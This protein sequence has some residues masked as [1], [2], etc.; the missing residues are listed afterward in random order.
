[1]EN[2]QIYPGSLHNHTEYSNLRLRDCIIRPE[3]LIDYA[4]EL[5]QEV[6]AITDHECVS[7][8]VRVEKYYN[9]IKENNPNFKLIRG[10]EIYLV[11]NGLNAD[12]YNRETDRYYH[13][14]LLAKDLIGMKQIFEISTRAWKR[15]YMARGMRR[16]PTYYQ[17]LIDVIGKNPGHIIGSTACLG[18]AIPVQILRAKENKKLLPLIENWLQQ[19]DSIFGHGNFFLELQP[20]HNKDQ[21]YVNK[22]LLQYSTTLNIPYIITTDSHYLKKEDRII[23]KAYLNAQN[24]D[25]EVDSFYATTYLMDTNELEGYFEYFSKEQ[26][27]EA[28]N[29]IKKI[30]DMCEDFTIQKPL[31]IPRLQWKECADYQFIAPK[32]YSKIPYLKTFYESDYEGDK[33]LADNIVYKLE[34]DKIHEF[35]NDETYEAINDNLQK[36]WDSSIVNKTHW[37]AYFLNLQKNIEECWNA[38]T[39]VGPGR[40]SGVGFIL[41]YLLDIIQINC[42][43]EPVKTYSFRFLNPARVSPLDVD[44]DIEGRQRTKVLEHFRKVYGEDR[45]AN[46]ATFKTEKSKSAILTAARGLGLDVDIAQYLSSLIPSDRGMIRSLDQCMYGD[47]ENGFAPIKQFVIEMTENYPEVWKVAHKIENLIC[48]YGLHAGGVIFV[49]EP[50]TEST[51]LLRAPEGTIATQFDLHDD[52][53]CSLIKIDLLSVECLDKIHI[54]LDLLKEYGYIDKNLTL[55]E[56]YEQTIG[57]YNLDRNSEEM[58]KMVWNH[59]IFSLFQMEKQSGING[60]DLTKPKSIEDLAHLNSIIRLMAQE[61]GAETPLEK[62]SRYKENIK[63]WYEEMERYGLTENEIKVIEPVLKGSYGICESQEAFMTLLQ[64]PECGGFDLNF[65]DK[66]R[67]AIAKKNPK[68]YEEL[69]EIYFKTTKEK[70]LSPKLC[71]YVWNVCIATSRGYGFNL[72]HTLAY[73]LVALQEMNLAYK[74][75][76]EFWNCA[77]LISDSGSGDSEDEDN[78]EKELFEDDAPIYSNEMEEFT[79]E[80]ND[81]DIENSYEE[82]DCD[83]YPAEVEILKDGKKKKKVK[84]TNYGRISAAIGKMKMEGIQVAPP[85]I[86]N[87]TY[88]FSPD[89]KNH[90]IRYGISGISMIGGDLVKEIIDKRPYTSIEDFT[91]RVKISKPKVVNLIKSGAFDEFG[92]RIELMKQYIESIADKKKRITLQNMK[93]L[94]E[95]EMIPE[96]FE[97]EI[98]IFNFNKYLKKNKDGKFYILNDYDVNFYN[99]YFNSDSLQPREDGNFQ[100]LQTVWDKI[101]D[102][103]M[104]PIRAYFKAN[105]KEILDNLNDKLVSEVWNKY[106]KGSISAWEMD[107][108]SYYSHPHELEKLDNNLYGISDFYELPLEP[109]IDRIITIKGKQIP[110]YKIIR[111]AGTVLDRDKA[112]KTIT[113]LT[114]SGVITVKIFGQV[115]AFYDKQISERGEDGK[116]HVIQKSMFRRGNKIIV[117]GIRTGENEMLGKKYKSTPWHLCEEISKINEDGTIETMTRYEE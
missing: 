52:E 24:G 79:E 59:K 30:K 85:D 29:N 77:N 16:V 76:I 94:I 2:I 9:S 87:S 17:D 90:I 74:F 88:T 43:R 46:V 25:R 64:I 50:F 109:Q 93:M 73:S 108:V 18:G 78:S 67:K 112:K 97:K 23:H 114:I 98:K 57:I 54:C 28:Y 82:E 106:A 113:L 42:L 61:K 11:R 32:Y 31:R 26:I 103:A 10:N 68:A 53:A 14:I 36:T 111:V 116:K 86:N 115:F 1:M 13:F 80:D 107:S 58:W 101:Y 34:N 22:A 19:M 69:T 40:G 21:I 110:L 3:E 51:A 47:E 95:K 117:S 62:Y 91:S 45:V 55:R 37:S 71:N 15:S 39:I 60:I 75:P 104:N 92:D 105:Q 102:N 7:N 5:G 44:T 8:A 38:G 12:N 4:I 48:G 84:S 83:G 6:V 33:K 100:I 89:P 56:A 27:Y 70:G 72:S 20:S 49:D 35:D 63:L 66:V 65:A 81:E 96:D 99:E 41:L